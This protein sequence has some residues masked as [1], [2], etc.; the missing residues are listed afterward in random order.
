MRKFF[1][2]IISITVA[3]ISL[4]L[5]VNWYLNCHEI[6]PLIGIVTSSGILL[7]ALVYRIFSEK[8][9]EV[10]PPIRV[11]SGK[12]MM[13]DST[14]KAGGSVQIGDNI[15][16]LYQN[17]EVGSMTKN[18][19]LILIAIIGII[20]ITLIS[21]YWI[22]NA[23]S[24][25]QKEVG[26]SPAKTDTLGKKNAEQLPI[27]PPSTKSHKTVQEAKEKRA[28]TT[29]NRFESRDQSKQINLPD[30]KGTIII[31]Q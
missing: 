6:E 21:G 12:N 13:V 28:D 26:V 1:E 7:T 11:E 22:K 16:N 17:K 8:K 20:S 29:K 19:R 4:A 15:I 24:E 30:N 5:C 14:I 9:E 18:N 2:N 27:R 31:N 23:L 10:N 3:L 25:G